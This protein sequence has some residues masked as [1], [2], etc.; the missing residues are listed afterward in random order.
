MILI[1]TIYGYIHKLPSQE[2]RDSL[3]ELLKLCSDAELTEIAE[4]LG[5]EQMARQVRTPLRVRLGVP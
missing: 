1:P 3:A 4:V 2:R 5:Q